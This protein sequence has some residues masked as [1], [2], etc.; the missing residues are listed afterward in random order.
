[1]KDSPFLATR[2]PNETGEYNSSIM[3]LNVNAT[4]SF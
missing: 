1:M 3:F 2:V 4:L